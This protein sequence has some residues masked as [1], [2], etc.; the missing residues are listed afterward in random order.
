MA[1]EY[2]MPGQF[3]V[4]S[5]VFGFG[6]LIL[7]MVMG[8]RNQCFQNGESTEDLLSFVSNRPYQFKY[9]NVG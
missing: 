7:E 1:P 8:E 2:A 6:V 5:D 3:S 9:N 4:K